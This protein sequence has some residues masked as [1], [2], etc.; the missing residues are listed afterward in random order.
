MDQLIKS[1]RP[2]RVDQVR[3]K[4]GSCVA[5][6]DELGNEWAVVSC[7]LI[8]PAAGVRLGV[9]VGEYQPLDDR[10][11]DIRNDSWR[12]CPFCGGVH[13]EGRK[14]WELR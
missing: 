1:P 9:L 13:I 7:S 8:E 4:D 11:V 5:V 6:V 12:R 3:Y 2:L 14:Q 10:I